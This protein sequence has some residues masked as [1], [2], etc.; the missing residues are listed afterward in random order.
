MHRH[1]RVLAAGVVAILVPL[2]GCDSDP[3]GLGKGLDFITSL[4]I[5]PNPV[6]YSPLTAEVSLTTTRP[7]QIELVIPGRN[8]ATSETRQLFDITGAQARFPILGLYANAT[9]TITLRFLDGNTLLGETSRDIET[10]PLLVDL[11][12]VT[13]DAATPGAMKPGTKYFHFK[14]P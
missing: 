8:G 7:V 10:Q 4:T 13:I 12:E 6:G 3:T 2:L 1:R 14:L 9:N 5:T 11:P